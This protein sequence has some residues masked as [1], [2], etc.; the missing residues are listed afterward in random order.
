[1]VGIFFSFSVFG[2]K[3][4]VG[5]IDRDREMERGKVKCRN[6][7]Y[8]LVDRC[9]FFFH[10]VEKRGKLGEINQNQCKKKNNGFE[11][12]NEEGFIDWLV[13]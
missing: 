10:I 2:F 4:N 11:R 12:D 3:K 5:G 1:M 9:S 6:I 13:N 8:R 7:I